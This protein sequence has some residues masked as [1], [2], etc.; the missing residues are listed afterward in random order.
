MATHRTDVSVRSGVPG[1][2]ET[3]VGSA[4]I[5]LTRVPD[6]RLHSEAA[7]IGMIARAGLVAG[8]RSPRPRPIGG[9]P[10]VVIRSYPREGTLVRRGTRVDYELLPGT[11]TDAPEPG[12]PA[13]QV[14]AQGEA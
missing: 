8:Q 12:Q 6:V 2:L 10:E 4:D 9:R 14:A 3:T 13:R 1:L 7:A 5:P 11:S